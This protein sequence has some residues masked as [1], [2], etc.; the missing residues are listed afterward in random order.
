MNFKLIAGLLVLFSLFGV[1][2]MAQQD[3][4][5]QGVA[6][7]VRM[8]FTVVPDANTNQLNV[9]MNL[10]LFNDVQSLNSIALGF[11]WLNNNLRMTSG[12][13]TPDGL[14]IFDMMH[15]VYRNGRIDS[16]NKYR[17]FQCTGARGGES[18]GLVAS[19]TAKHVATYNFVLSSW[20]VLDSI[21]FDSMQ[22]LGATFTFV[23]FSNTE[24]R[25]IWKSRLVIYDANRPHITGVLQTNTNNLSF[26]G[27]AGSSAPPN[28]SF[29]VSE[30]VGD[31]IPF[32]AAASTSWITLTN[33]SG[34]TPGTVGVG[35][36]M[37]GLTA[38]DYQGRVIVTSAEAT[39]ADTVAINLH[40]ALPNQPPV[41]ASI[42]NRQVNENSLLQ[43]DV[44]ATDPDG[45]TPLLTTSALPFGAG[46]VDHG[47]GTGTF[48]WI[49]GFNAAGSYP[50]TFTASDG[51]LTD[52]EAITITVMDVNRPPVLAG[53]GPQ[54]VNE[55]AN[56]TFVA[57]GTDPDE[58]ALT[59]SAPGIP[60]TATF[61]DHGDG[62]ATFS[63]TP[64]NTDAGMHTFW[65]IVSDGSLAD[66]EF[67]TVEVL[68]MDGFVVNPMTLNFS[69]RFHGTNP[70]PQ[71]VHV[72]IG[73]GSQASFVATTSDSWIV[74]DPAPATTPADIAVGV[75]IADLAAGVYHGS[76][77]IM[78]NI[79]TTPQG[80][81][82]A[83]PPVTVEVNLTIGNELV[84]SETEIDMVQ[85][86]GAPAAATSSFTVSEAGG[87]AIAFAVSSGA[88]WFTMN[89]MSGTTSGDV[90]V[91]FSTELA[92][93]NYFDS[94]MVT[95]AA[96]VNSPLKVYV[97]FMVTACPTFL[98]TAVVYNVQTFAGET[99]IVSE[100][101]QHWQ[102]RRLNPVGGSPGRVF[103]V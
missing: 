36:N 31:N 53:I 28:Q 21:V 2:A 47:N 86:E 72:T 12:A 69:G 64:N 63:W 101:F 70:A 75:N 96:A 78:D 84:V 43:F 56:L 95:S 19:M 16:T 9:S 93:G 80:S 44:T 103:F 6:D 68:D 73:D 59:L 87:G 24:Y 90:Q 10:Y 32:T 48:S 51:S 20:S 33:A 38:G 67:V 66:S 100:S 79:P 15:M 50:V 89:P 25:P 35:I 99:A 41:L 34:T 8:D 81:P 62:T 29:D 58:T 98:T 42:G 102:H 92:P 14:V 76:I 71:T 74:L 83:Y 94:I 88:T 23:D 3:P 17:A 60:S 52:F 27:V 22:V 7:T 39:N 65:V 54:M 49:P 30:A 91:T 55:G 26:T 85:S 13:F 1:T 45:A 37:T 18:P 57:S 97:R 11:G 40:L 4:L 46:F 77:Q 61:T 82:A 5:D